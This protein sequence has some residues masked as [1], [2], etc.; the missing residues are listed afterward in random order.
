MSRLIES[1]SK[2]M[3]IGLKIIMPILIAYSII[4]TIGGYSIILL[5]ECIK[6]NINYGVLLMS[7]LVI[8]IVIGLIIFYGIK[9]VN[10]YYIKNDNR[11]IIFVILFIGFLLR[12]LWIASV[13]TLPSSDFKLVWNAGVNVLDGNYSVMH[14]VSYLARFPHLIIT[15]LYFGFIQLISPSPLFVVKLINVILSIGSIYLIYGIVKE[16]FNEKYGLYASILASVYPA[17]IMY[18][19]LT[20]SENIA[21]PLYLLSLYIFIRVI[22]GSLNNNYL[23]LSG[24]IL[25][26]GNMFR[27]VG[28]VILIAYIMYLI[29]YK[30]KNKII[31][32]IAKVFIA[33][34]LPLIVISNVLVSTNMSEYQLWSGVEPKITSILKGSNISALG[35]WNWEDASI[36]EDYNYDKVKIEDA[37]KEIISDR[38]KNKPLIRTIAFYFAKYA[39]LWGSGDFSAYYWTTLETDNINQVDS[40]AYALLPPTQLLFSVMLILMYIG[41]YDKRKVRNNELDISYLLYGGF[42]ILYS[43]TEQQS[44]YGYIVSFLFIIF[45]FKGIEVLSINRKNN[46]NKKIY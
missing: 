2:F 46:L 3:N 32:S 35:R 44:R 43:I 39:S 7:S 1:F 23:I 4:F 29:I 20:C 31:N 40:Y 27:M 22:K 33:Y 8:T 24:L 26:F 13:K 34:S 45:M 17:F 6:N 19:S 37:C 16:T 38:L 11:K 9:F 5:E 41:L 10:R 25:S 21:M 12:I 42:I 15:M 30:T 14:G 36:S 18:T 28:S